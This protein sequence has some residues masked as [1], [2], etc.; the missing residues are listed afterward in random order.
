MRKGPI[1]GIDEEHVGPPIGGENR[2]RSARG[3]Y[4]QARDACRETGALRFE[5]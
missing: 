5:F 3:E 4:Q 1:V 2:I